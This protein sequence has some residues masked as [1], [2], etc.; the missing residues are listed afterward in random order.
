MSKVLTVHNAELTTAAVEINTMKVSGKQVTL[1]TFRQLQEEPVVDQG[2]NLCGLPWGTVNYHPDR[3]ADSDEHL[4]VVWQKGDELRRAYEKP[5]K[6][7]RFFPVSAECLLDALTLEGW[8]PDKSV[9]AYGHKSWP[10]EVHWDIGGW[11]D[12]T[13]DHHTIW[14][15]VPKKPGDDAE[16]WEVKHYDE[17]LP[18]YNA[19]IDAIR[20]RCGD[21]SVNAARA[22]L[23]AEL[24][25]EKSRRRRCIDRWNE[26]KA[27]PQIF[28]AV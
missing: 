1:A 13:K 18:K 12:C 17:K 9:S 16:R 21:I 27:L 20:F 25:E 24:E 23:E 22:A 15:G 28:I 26:L 4:H 10:G 5:P 2:G 7:G 6:F 11:A 14:D 19:A 3:C 8:V